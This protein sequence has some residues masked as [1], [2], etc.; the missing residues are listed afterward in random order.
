M[1]FVLLCSPSFV[2]CPTV[3]QQTP[4]IIALVCRFKLPIMCALFSNAIYCMDPWRLLPLASYFDRC[5][6][7]LSSCPPQSACY[8]SVAMSLA[9]GSSLNCRSL[10]LYFFSLP[11]PG[12]TVLTFI[13]IQPVELLFLHLHFQFATR[14][15]Q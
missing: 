11:M 1:I 14:H 13:Y 10:T 15:V 12:A 2:L 7:S 3:V 9:F 4:I 8:S 6:V 5:N